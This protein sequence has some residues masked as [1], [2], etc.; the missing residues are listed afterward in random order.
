MLKTK[1]FA[2]IVF[3]SLIFA[4]LLISCG[5]DSTKSTVFEVTVNNTST[6]PGYISALTPGVFFVHKGNSVAYTVGQAAPSNGLESYA[7]DGNPTALIQSL[8]LADNISLTGIVDSSSTAQQ[9]PLLPG[10]NYRF[11]IAA[12]D[13]DSRLSALF[14]FTRKESIFLRDHFILMLSRV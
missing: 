4:W 1:K 5:S 10:R 8:G 11:V 14:K 2:S 13:K 3:L 7:E 6:N 9:G 12:A